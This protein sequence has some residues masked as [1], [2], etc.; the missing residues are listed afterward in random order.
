MKATDVVNKIREV[1]GVELSAEI[2]LAQETLENGTIIEAESLEAG[3]EVFIVNEEERIALPVGE[4][5]MADGKVLV[6]AEEGVIAEIKEKAEE[7]PEETPEE[8]EAKEDE[9][10]VEAKEEISAPKKVVES[11]TKE[12]HFSAE[13]SEIIETKLSELKAELK[14]EILAELKAENEVK[15][16]ELSK[17]ELEAEPFHHNP[18]MVDKNA[19]VYNKAFAPTLQNRIFQKLNA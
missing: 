17:V 19:P 1:L 14:A 15:K 6:V 9:V 3:K 12:T 4:Y 13:Q 10:E 7:T 2:K 11:V 8:T 16:E 5:Q 18:E